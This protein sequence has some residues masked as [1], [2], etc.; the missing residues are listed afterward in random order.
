MH[1]Y[2]RSM[3]EAQSQIYSELTQKSWK[4][5]EHII[6]LLLL[7]DCPEANHW[8]R[9]IARFIDSVDRLKGKNRFPDAK[10]IKKCISTHNDC[11]DAFLYKISGQL[12]EETQRQL[13]EDV[14]LHALDTYQNWLASELSS[15]GSIRYFDA[16]QVLDDIIEQTR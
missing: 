15:H 9:E 16:Y 13:S 3:S 1:I 7:P 10:F 6:K 4:V 11:I 8:K 12:H 5:D 14:I 2:I